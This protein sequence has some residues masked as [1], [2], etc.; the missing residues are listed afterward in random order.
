VRSKEDHAL[1]LEWLREFTPATRLAASSLP[2][3]E[4]NRLLV[5]C[6]L[7]AKM[8]PYFEALTEKGAEV[9]ACAANPAT[10]RDRVAEH[11]WLVD[12]CSSAC[13]WPSG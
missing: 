8:I 2:S 13:C 6:H 11:R 9:W 5:V 3:L 10:T 7:D 4:G 12:C 1:E